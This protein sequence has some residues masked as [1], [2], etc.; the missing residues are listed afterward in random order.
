MVARALGQPVPNELGLVRGRVVEDQV[1]VQVRWKTRLDLVEELAEFH[2]TV[3]RVAP[4][5]HL[6]G[7]HVE[8]R[9]Q[10]RG[11]VPDI[12]VRAPFRLPWAQRQKR[13]RAVERLYLAFLIHAQHEGAVGRGQIQTDDVAHLSAKNGSVDSLK[14]SDRCG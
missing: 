1:N 9:K 10:A 8:S 6:A 5:D 13:L 3:T 2:G 7:R 12:I 14:V 11:S 4:S